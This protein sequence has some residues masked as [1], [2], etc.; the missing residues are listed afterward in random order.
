MAVTDKDI[1]LLW[2]RSGERCSICRCKLSY[3]AS[4]SSDV[5]PLGEQ[6][7]IVARSLDGPRGTSVLALAERDSYRNLILLCPTHHTLID[8]CPEDYPPERLHR[9]KEK[10]EA[11][12][13]LSLGCTPRPIYS[14]LAGAYTESIFLHFLDHYFLEMKD[15]RG[16]ARETEEARL[17][18]RLALLVADHIL[19]PASA[20]A[21]SALCRLIVD[22]FRP[23]FERGCIW[24]VGAGASFVEYLERKMDQYPAGSRHRASYL[25]IDAWTAPP[26]LTRDVSATAY[27]S[28]S[29][30][31]L[32]DTELPLKLSR[33]GKVQEAH[34][35]KRWEV[36]PDLLGDTAFI[37]EHVS[38]L[39]LGDAPTRAQNNGLHSVINRSYYE[40]FIDEFGCGVVEDLV[41]LRSPFQIKPRGGSF[42]FRNL[43]RELLRRGLLR[44]VTDA[45]PVELLEI[46]HDPRWLDSLSTC[47][48]RGELTK[49]SSGGLHEKSEF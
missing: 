19:V 11:W 14:L 29:W 9:L 7:H 17:A 40:S 2:G 36:I 26:F 27:I 24:Q 45:P 39:L 33:R 15:A 44:E 38:P 25:E 18:T 6:A 37:V 31:K 48:E 34:F 12:V 21:E 3:E 10:H 13:H 32:L 8:S 1:K 35:E 46:R 4:A 20:Y 30:L 49:T 5:V 16:H 28:N 22:E 43:S 42:S 41:Y 23:L 47:L